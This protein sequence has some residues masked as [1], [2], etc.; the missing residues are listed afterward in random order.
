MRKVSATTL[1][2]VGVRRA[3][4]KAVVR[5]LWRRGFGFWWLLA[6]LAFKHFATSWHGL[7]GSVKDRP[8]ALA[9]AVTSIKWALSVAV[10]V[11]K[12]VKTA[13]A[14]ETSFYRILTSPSIP[15]Y[16]V[17]AIKWWPMKKTAKKETPAKWDTHVYLDKKTRRAVEVIASRERRSLTSQI[18]VFIHQGLELAAAK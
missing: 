15:W 17:G 6:D 2:T 4:F 3:A 7:G 13:K 12:C 9:K 11:T 5:Y 10:L 16:P 14:I 8:R 1:R 18:A